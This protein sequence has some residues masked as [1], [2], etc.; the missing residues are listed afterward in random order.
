VKIDPGTHKGMHSVLALKLGVTLGAKHV[1]K[2]LL[3]PDL[4]TRYAQRLG[5]TWVNSR[6]PD[7]SGPGTRYV[8]K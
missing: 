5:L 3:E 2:W 8:W 4:G 7:M 1:R 6:S